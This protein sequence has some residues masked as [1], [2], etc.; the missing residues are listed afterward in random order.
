MTRPSLTLVSNPSA[1]SSSTRKPA[2]SPSSSA[3]P[4]ASATLPASP[5]PPGILKAVTRAAGKGIAEDTLRIA[6]KPNRIILAT[7]LNPPV[8]EANVL[9]SRYPKASALGLAGRKEAGL[10]RMGYALTPD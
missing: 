5:T 2:L 10:Q 8:P 6:G 9:D 3:T 4:P 7:A 1:T